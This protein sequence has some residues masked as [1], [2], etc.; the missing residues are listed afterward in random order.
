MDSTHTPLS[1]LQFENMALVLYRGAGLGPDLA[2]TLRE[3]YYIPVCTPP[4]SISSGTKGWTCSTKWY[5]AV[6]DPTVDSNVQAKYVF[7]PGITGA[8]GN[9][10]GVTYVTNPSDPNHP[11][12]R[13][14]LQR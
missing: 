4:G 10:V 13:D 8:F 2:S 9:H 6:N 14:Q 1:G 5:W 3:L 7:P 12:V 11:G